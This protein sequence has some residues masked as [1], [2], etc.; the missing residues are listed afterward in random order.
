MV[1]QG[2]SSTTM[3][4]SRNSRSRRRAPAAGEV[5]ATASPPVVGG[6]LQ[7]TEQAE[8]GGPKPVAAPLG[9]AS[10]IPGRPPRLWVDTAGRLLRAGR[11]HLDAGV[12]V[13]RQ[14]PG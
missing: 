3:R 6:A 10:T 13:S 4:W 8:R 5:T 9:L 11:E 7:C 12:P 2:P 1:P 14:G